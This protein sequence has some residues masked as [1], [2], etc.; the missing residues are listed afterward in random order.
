MHKA[1]KF[2]VGVMI[3]PSNPTC[4]VARSIYKCLTH[5]TTDIK[6]ELEMS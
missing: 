3:K 5:H 2:L 1:G 6:R 4:V